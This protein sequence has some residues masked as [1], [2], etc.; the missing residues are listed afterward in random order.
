MVVLTSFSSIFRNFVQNCY[1]IQQG[2]ILFR[3]CVFPLAFSGKSA[4]RSDLFWKLYDTQPDTI[5]ASAAW[6]RLVPNSEYVHGYG[7]RLAQKLNAS[8]QRKGKYNEKRRRVYCGAYAI[9]VDAV[10]ALVDA[11][12]LP[13][14]MAADVVHKIEDD[15]L[16]HAALLIKVIP[17]QTNLEATKT[18]IIDR[19]WNSSAGPDPHVCDC[20]KLLKPHPSIFLPAGPLGIYADTRTQIKRLWHI[21][22]FHIDCRILQLTSRSV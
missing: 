21:V 3:H 14:I 10:R 18:A 1:Q 5:E 6:E 13:E 11:E 15:E 2:E 16:A 4:F 17:T 7:C 8:E 22:R 9:T 20:D 19:L 12:N